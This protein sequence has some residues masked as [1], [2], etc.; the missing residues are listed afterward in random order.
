M[1]IN[2]DKF[3]EPSELGAVATEA[4]LFNPDLR[5]VVGTPSGVQESATLGGDFETWLLLTSVAAANQI[6]AEFQGRLAPGQTTIS[7][8][9][10]PIKGTG[11]AQYTLKVYVEGT[12]QVYTSGITAAPGV[13]TVLAL[14]NLDLS[15]QPT[16]E[17][18][19]FIVV[20]A[21]LDGAEALRVGLPFVKQE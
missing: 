5:V 13:R 4:Y 14:T 8:I 12:G 7:S 6:N 11:A 9:K 16:G 17:K 15:A 19:Y 3:L 20:E 10:V 1:V 2:A 18:R 21:T